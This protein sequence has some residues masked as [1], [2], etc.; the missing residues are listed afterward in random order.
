VKLPDV[1]VEGVRP[2]TGRLQVQ[3]DCRHRG[4]EFAL[5]GILGV[6]DLLTDLVDSVKEKVISHVRGLISIIYL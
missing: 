2:I 1:L 6:F 3:L 5:E 4:A